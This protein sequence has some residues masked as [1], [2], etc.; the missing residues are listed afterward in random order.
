MEILIYRFTLSYSRKSAVLPENGSGV[1]EGT[2][3]SFVTAL[4]GSVAYLHSLVEYLPELI[5]ISVRGKC[6]VYKVNGYDALVEAAVILR[7]TVLVDI[8]SEEAAASHT[9]VAVTLAVLIDLTLEHYLLGDVVGN[10]TLSGTLSRKL[11]EI[12]ILSSGTDVILLENIYKLRECGGDVYACLI[13]NALVSLNKRFLNYHS[14]VGTLRL[15]LSLSEIH[16]YRN[17][18]SLSVRRKKSYNLVLNTLNALPYLLAK[19]ALGNLID[20]LRV[21]NTHLGK[22][23]RHLLL[24]LLAADLNEGSKMRQTY[25]LTAVLVRCNLSYN[26]SGDVAGGREAMGL[27]NHSSADNSSILKHILKVNEVAVM[28]MLCEVICIVEVNKTFLV[29]LDYLLGQKNSS[30]NILR[31]L[32]RHIVTLN[33][34]DGGVLIRILLLN[35]FVIALDE[36]HNLLVGGIRLSYKLSFISVGYISLRKVERS[37]LHNL[38]FN[39]VLH[40]LDACRAREIK[41]GSLNRERNSIYSG[42]GYSLILLDCRIR[43]SYRCSYLFAVKNDLCAVSLNK[44]HSITSP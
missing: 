42:V 10:H 39:E 41:A 18:G 15:G 16:K 27:L 12:V 25:R 44:L 2:R 13:L 11:G 37:E 20:S 33:A 32:A 34:V 29:R 7:L 6:D 35:L 22:L 14:E 38:A 36:R 8:R 43:L 31:Y 3:E 5:N 24:Y 21:G 26:L 30:R 40:L 1:G 23:A 4:E 17:E 19:S 9:G 28:H